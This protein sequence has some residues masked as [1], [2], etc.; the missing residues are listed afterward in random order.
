MS[1][2]EW[3]EAVVVLRDITIE[4]NMVAIPTRDSRSR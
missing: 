4:A 3:E 1:K 2:R